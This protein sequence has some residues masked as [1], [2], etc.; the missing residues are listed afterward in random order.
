MMRTFRLPSS[1]AELHNISRV[2]LMFTTVCFTFTFLDSK[3][4]LR[5]FESLF[6]RISLHLLFLLFILYL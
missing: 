6:S 4:V 5:S 1:M 3:L 2:C